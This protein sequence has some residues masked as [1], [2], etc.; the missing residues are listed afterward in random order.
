MA[1]QQQLE[2]WTDLSSKV[3]M[4]TGA[5]SG[6]GREFCLDLGKAGCRIVAAAR[7]VDRLKSLCD[8]INGLSFPEPQSS[9]PRAVHVELDVCA[10]GA[11]IKSRVKAAWDAFGRIDVLINNAGIRGSVKDSLELLEEEW[12]QT[13]RTN[14]RGSW[15]V[16]KYVATHMRDANQGGSIINIS[17]ITGLNRPQAPGGLAYAS[18]KA[19]LNTLTKVVHLFLLLHTCFKHVLLVGFCLQ[20][21]ASHGTRDAQNPSELDIARAF[22]I[23]DHARPCEQGLAT[24]RGYENSPFKNVWHDRSSIDLGG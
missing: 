21:H 14:L 18:S 2:P 20:I 22:Q 23:R 24:I 8:E 12:D 16:S 13:M 1:E 17:S 3:V 9:G 15:L 4:V 10:D 7:R 5:S 11:T 19:A 6:L